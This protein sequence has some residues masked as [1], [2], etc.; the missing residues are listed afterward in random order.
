[1]K[2]PFRPPSEFAAAS[3]GRTAEAAE[4]DVRADSGG[5]VVIVIGGSGVVVVRGLAVACFAAAG[6]NLVYLLFVLIL[7]KLVKLF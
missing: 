4:E 2:Y 1:M 5:E 6:T 7:K 3:P